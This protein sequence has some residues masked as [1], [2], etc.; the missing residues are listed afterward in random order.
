MKA[1][2]SIFV[3]GKSG[4]TYS[5]SFIGYSEHLQE[6]E[7]EGFEIVEVCNTIPILAHRLGLTSLWAWLQDKGVIS[8]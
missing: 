3:K 7:N 2:Y 4:N 6:W 8:Y 5:F 1:K